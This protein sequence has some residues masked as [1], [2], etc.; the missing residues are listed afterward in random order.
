MEESWACGRGKELHQLLSN[1]FQ[2]F[3]EFYD[4]LITQRNRNW[5]PGIL[6]IMVTEQQNVLLVVGTGHLVGPGS[7]IELLQKIH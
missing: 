3:P 1:S 6:K 5:V 4:L 7:V 2:E